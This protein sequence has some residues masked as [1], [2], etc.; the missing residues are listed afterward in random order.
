MRFLVEVERL[1]AHKA[2]DALEGRAEQPAQALE[3]LLA[4]ELL[5]GRRIAF[6]QPGD[7]RI[8]ELVQ[9][10]GVEPTGEHVPDYT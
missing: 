3:R 9:L 10:F 1:G 4:R 6:E 5:A 2:I 8:G 7:R